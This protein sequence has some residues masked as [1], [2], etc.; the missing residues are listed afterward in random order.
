PSF[1]RGHCLRRERKTKARSRSSER[2]SGLVVRK[3]IRRRPTL[4]RSF[5]RSTIGSERLNFRVRDGNGCDPLDKTT[6][7]LERAGKAP[8]GFENRIVK[9]LEL[10]ASSQLLVSKFYGQAMGLISTGK[11]NVLPRFHTQPINV[12]V[13]HGSH[14]QVSSWVW[15]H[16]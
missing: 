9:R 5:P 2:P 15:L 11:L 3:I 7:N 8:K 12:V 6:G 4:P 1:P 13:Y 10:C 16:A 14:G